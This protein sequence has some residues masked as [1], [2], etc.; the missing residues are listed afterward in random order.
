MFNHKSITVFYVIGKFRV[1]TL[2]RSLYSYALKTLDFALSMTYLAVLI[3]K[4]IYLCRPHI[5]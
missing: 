1:L 2:I 3:W 5:E 4:I